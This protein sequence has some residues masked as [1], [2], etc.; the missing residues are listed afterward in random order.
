MTY[1]TMGTAYVEPGYTVT[2][3]ADANVQVRQCLHMII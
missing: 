2:D 1:L 3:N